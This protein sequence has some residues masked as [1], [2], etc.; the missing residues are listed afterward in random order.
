MSASIDKPWLDLYSDNVPAEIDPP[1]ENALDMFLSASEKAPNSAL[2]HYFNNTL[3]CQ[4]INQYSDALAMALHE[5]E[6]RHGDR[7]AIYM[8]NMPQYILTLLATWKLSAIVVPVNPMYRR[9]EL[10]HV[11]SDSGS[12]VLVCQESLFEEVARE[13]VPNTPVKFTITSS[14]LDF[15]NDEVPA[16][17]EKSVKQVPGDTDDLWELIKKHDGTRP[18]AMDISASEL[19]FLVYTSGTTGPPKGAMI[20]HVNVVAISEAVRIWADLTSEDTILAIAPLFHITG[21]IVHITLALLTLSPVVLFYRFDP[22]LAARLTEQYRATF[23]AGAITA[24]NAMMNAKEV[25]DYDLSSLT[26]IFCGGA[27]NPPAV[28]EAVEQKLGIYL[29]GAYGMT[30]ATAPTHYVPLGK[31][32]PV[33]EENN[34]LSVGVPIC[35]VSARIIDEQGNELAAGEI[36]EIAIR[37]PG[38]ISGY[39]NKAEET[40]HAIRDGELRSGDVGYM[41]EKGWFYIVDRMKDLI[42]ASGYKVWPREVE[43]ALYEHPSVREAAV[44][45]VADDYRGET[46][47]AFISLKPGQTATEQELIDHCGQLLAA[48]KRPHAIDILDE[49]PKNPSGKILRRELRDTNKK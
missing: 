43:D 29:H 13:V 33:D 19:A 12:T 20:S 14:E 48:Y 2:V 4:D 31:R 28:V 15:L 42:I 8:Q 24:F 32:A 1:F 37:S 26:K 27:P 18:A 39:W 44:I 6:V 36:G 40:E 10:T 21:L 35:G 22:V 5:R 17:L 7:V 9:T 11:L 49:L 30:E 25:A 16:S 3:S 45:G 38:V 46:V 47:K 34:A 23:S 41:D